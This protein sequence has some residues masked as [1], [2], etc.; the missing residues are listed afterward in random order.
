MLF[1]KVINDYYRKNLVQKKILSDF[2]ECQSDKWCEDV[3]TAIRKQ[4]DKSES[5]IRWNILERPEVTNYKKSL[6]QR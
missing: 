1:F 5:W 3:Q 6:I 2:S 4:V